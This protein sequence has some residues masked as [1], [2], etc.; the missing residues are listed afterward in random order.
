MQIGEIASR[1]IPVLAVI[2]VVVAI[3]AIIEIALTL[4]KT[5]SVIEAASE[6]V[7][8]ANATLA[9]VDP[10]IEH[11]T[12]TVDA[13]NLEIMR[14]DQILEDVEQ[15]TDAATSAAETVS[16][17]SAAPME[18]VNSLAA[19][20]RS[21]AKSRSR[22]RVAEKAQAQNAIEQGIYEEAIAQP[23]AEHEADTALNVAEAVRADMEDEKH[24]APTAK[25]AVPKGVTV[26]EPSVGAA[27][28][29]KPN[30]GD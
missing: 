5:R 9:S 14:V 15:V 17:L 8:A 23:E 30:D 21:G 26:I 11:A 20:F 3:W 19:H 13:L 4:R 1:A 18:I 29:D 10:L 25:V 22:A 12:L 28:A 7:E 24:E 6:T 16:Q 2:L 27:T